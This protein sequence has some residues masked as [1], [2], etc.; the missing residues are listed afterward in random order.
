M[1]VAELLI[2]GPARAGGDGGGEVAGDETGQTVKTS[3]DLPSGSIVPAPRGRYA[4]IL[5][6][7]LLAL[8]VPMYFVVGAW[9]T[10]RPLYVPELAL[11]RAVPFE[12][13]W[14]VVYSSLYLFAFLP[15]F[16]VTPQALLRRAV[17]AYLMAV[18]LAYVG[19]AAYPVAAP[20]P[21]SVTG[22]D[23]FAWCV[24]FIYWLDTPYNC[25]PSLHVAYSFLAAFTCYRVNRGVGLVA[26]AWASLIGIS[27]LF[28]KQHFLVDVLAGVF[29][30]YAAS[31]VFLRTYPRS[32]I[33][34]IDRRRAPIRA[35]TAV[36]LFALLVASFWTAYAVRTASGA[37]V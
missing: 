20:R 9:T 30:A 6:G 22:H 28:I 12:P 35:L 32:A 36:G 37:G 18:V 34:E 15:L 19:F 31:L 8:L 13:A 5:P 7:V 23:F 25:F 26:L 21:H 27:T 11:D 24:R 14:A 1:R 4:N 17:L 3:D 2:A 29:L 33:P 10:G 16:V